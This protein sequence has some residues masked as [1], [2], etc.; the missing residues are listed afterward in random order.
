MALQPKGSEAVEQ[1]GRGKWW[2]QS[3]PVRIS[4]MMFVYFELKIRKIKGSALKL[5]SHPKFTFR[6]TVC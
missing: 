1:R 3:H 2:L 6:G 5:Q 4:K